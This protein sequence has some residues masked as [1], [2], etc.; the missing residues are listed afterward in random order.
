MN[1]VASSN[2]ILKY[3][4]FTPSGCKDIGIRTFE[5][6]TKAQ[7]IYKLSNSS[8]LFFNVKLPSSIADTVNTPI[9][10]GPAKI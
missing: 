5:I 10:A 8:N 4:R 9:K 7:F 6:L 2:Q 3:Q 1:S